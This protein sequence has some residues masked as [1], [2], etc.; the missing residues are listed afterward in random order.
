VAEAVDVPRRV[1]VRDLAA[2]AGVNVV[3]ARRKNVGI[4]RGR[5]INSEDRSMCNEQAGN[6]RAVDWIFGTLAGIPKEQDRCRVA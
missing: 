5:F 2:P 1:G 3:L 6:A 4:E